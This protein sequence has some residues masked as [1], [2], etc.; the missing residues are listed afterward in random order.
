MNSHTGALLAQLY[1]AALPDAL[2]AADVQ[3]FGDAP[4]PGWLA[5][6]SGLAFA[7]Q[8][9]LAAERPGVGLV[10][11]STCVD[12]CE[13]DPAQLAATV[14][15]D[16]VHGAAVARLLGVPLLSFAGAGQ[17]VRLTPGGSGQRPE[18]RRV[19]A[20]VRAVFD[21]L[22]LPPGSRLLDTDA[23]EIWALL[24]EQAE[25]DRAELP[26][27][28]LDGLYR[29]DDGSAFPAGTPFAFFYEYYRYN[30]ALYRRPVLAALGPAGAG[31]LVVENVQQVKAVTLARRLNGPWP[32][33]HLVTVP[34]PGRGAAERATRARSADRLLLDE[35]LRGGTP[36]EATLPGAT[37]A[38][39][40][41]VREHH[42]LL[43]TPRTEA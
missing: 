22:E 12:H 30:V 43:R 5:P 25:A 3:V 38:F 11:S 31:V 27:Q 20:A 2:A 13:G 32:T 8:A 42:T 29:L 34:A 10:L 1:S 6:L 23:P 7:G 26:D 16:L 15:A 18:W 17:E 40:S 19:S 39:W 4:T 33:Q 24:A 36:V 14:I 35:Y 28:R 37:A 9:G 41:A 21:A